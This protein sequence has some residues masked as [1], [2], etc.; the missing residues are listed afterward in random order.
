MHIYIFCIYIIIY[1]VAFISKLK[2]LFD[3]QHIL[4]KYEY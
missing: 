2:L 1:C 4:W 3:L